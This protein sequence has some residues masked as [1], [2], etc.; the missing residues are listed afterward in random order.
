MKI[1]KNPK[2]DNIVKD[3]FRGFCMKCATRWMGKQAGME[4]VGEIDMGD[5]VGYILRRKE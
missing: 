5:Q 3:K 4:M 1:C 2:C